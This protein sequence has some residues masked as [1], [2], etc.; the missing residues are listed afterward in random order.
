M[1]TPCL[2]AMQLVM[3]QSVD[4]AAHC[5]MHTSHP[6]LVSS[7]TPT[8]MHACMRTWGVQLHHLGPEHCILR[9]ECVAAPSERHEQA[10][11]IAAPIGQVLEE[12]ELTA[13]IW[14]EGR[15]RRRVMR[16]CCWCLGVDDVR[17]KGC[18]LA[19]AGDRAGACDRSPT[20]CLMRLLSRIAA[21]AV[22]DEV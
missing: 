6:I 16:S 22:S 4:P 7:E 13:A 8:C 18:R 15:R 19:A 11:L 14:L 5:Q 17:R 20:C 10:A 9:L 21:V 1:N 12:S 2:S 3:L